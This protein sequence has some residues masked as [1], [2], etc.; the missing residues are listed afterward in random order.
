MKKSIILIA[1]SRIALANA[2]VRFRDSRKF[3]L[4]VKFLN[5]LIEEDTSKKMA[6]PK[7][8]KM[9][10]I[11]GCMFIFSILFKTAI[12]PAVL[13]SEVRKVRILI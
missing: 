10:I 8:K 11:G 1:A 3:R 9:G 13:K 4:F 7:A 5:E 12:F 6:M 2:R